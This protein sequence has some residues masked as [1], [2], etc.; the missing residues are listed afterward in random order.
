MK[1]SLWLVLILIFTVAGCSYQ[2]QDDEVKRLAES[3]KKIQYEV[4]D[5]TAINDDLQEMKKRNDSIRPYF[6]EKAFYIFT[7]NNEVILPIKVAEKQK[8][9][10]EVVSISLTYA[11]QINEEFTYTYDLV[12]RLSYP[13]GKPSKEIKAQGQMDVTFEENRWKISRDW[14]GFPL[15]QEYNP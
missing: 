8:A 9:N 2:P 10:I 7:N 6:T 15:M 5:F 14:D 11:S 4:N 13:E 3:M 12:L 1:K